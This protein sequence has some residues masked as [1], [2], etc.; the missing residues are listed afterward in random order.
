MVTAAH[1]DLSLQLDS[2]RETKRGWY[3]IE[4]RVTLL[5]VAVH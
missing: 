4:L 5:A 1:F 3:T 2:N